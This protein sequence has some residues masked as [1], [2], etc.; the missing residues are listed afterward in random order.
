M[1]ETKTIFDK[2]RADFPNE[3]YSEDSSRG[4]SLTSI[5]AAYVIERLNDVFGLCGEGWKYEISAFSETKD[6][7]DQ[8]VEIGTKI[9]FQWL[10]E[11][12]E[13]SEPIPHVGGKR[14]VKGNITD[15]RKSSI[16]DALTKVASVLGVG[17]KVFKG[18]VKVGGPAPVKYSPPAQSAQT[19]KEAC[20]YCGTMSGTH[21]NNCP[22]LAT[23]TKHETPPTQTPTYSSTATEPQRKL[24][25][26]LSSVKGVDPEETKKMIKER[27]SLESFNDLTKKQASEIIDEIQ[28]TVH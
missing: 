3:A 27:Y 1:K 26:R 23:V 22:S 20:T 18:L 11:N 12:G 25:F 19:T 4:F 16:T 8:V 10:R 15:A 24:I 5:K 13:W 6:A 17:D 9:S 28:G 2:L 14:V 7:Q 21:K